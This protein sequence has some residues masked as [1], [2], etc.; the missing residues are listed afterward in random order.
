MWRLGGSPLPAG[1]F[2]LVA[3]ARSQASCLWNQASLLWGQALDRLP[4]EAQQLLAGQRVL[5][6]SSPPAPPAPSAAQCVAE[7]WRRA[8]AQLAAWA[9]DSTS[10]AAA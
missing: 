9:R 8:A 5:D 2:P 4:Q 7:L 1:L 6:S 3:E 10:S